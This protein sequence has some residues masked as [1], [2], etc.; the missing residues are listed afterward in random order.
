M[1]L[2]FSLP[3]AQFRCTGKLAAWRKRGMQKTGNWKPSTRINTECKDM[4]T[5]RLPHT[6]F[7]HCYATYFRGS[8]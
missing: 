3:T 2:E 7:F 8:G 5:L 4:Y 6:F 1:L